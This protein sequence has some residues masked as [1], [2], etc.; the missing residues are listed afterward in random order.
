LRAVDLAML[1][2]IFVTSADKERELIAISFE[3]GVEVEP[4]TLRFVTRFRQT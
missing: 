1:K 4:I 3:E 2:R